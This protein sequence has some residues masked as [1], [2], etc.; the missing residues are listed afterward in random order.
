MKASAEVFDLFSQLS[1]LAFQGMTIGDQE[2]LL[3][4]A[5]NWSITSECRKIRPIFGLAGETLSSD[6]IRIDVRLFE[7]GRCSVGAVTHIL[8]RADVPAFVLEHDVSPV[9][10]WR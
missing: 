10:S 7:G 6:E 4:G 8:V 2:R 1:Q 9:G 3:D 5:S